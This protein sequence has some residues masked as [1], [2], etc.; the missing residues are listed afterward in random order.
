MVRRAQLPHFPCLLAVTR[1]KAVGKNPIVERVR[2]FA[3][4]ILLDT[5]VTIRKV[6]T[7]GP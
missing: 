7:A 6:H 3:K 1:F 4:Y 2:T 5:E